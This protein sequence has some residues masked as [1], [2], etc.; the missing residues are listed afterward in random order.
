[1][2][3]SQ[4]NIVRN[5]NPNQTSS[6]Y[7]IARRELNILAFASQADFDHFGPCSSPLIQARTDT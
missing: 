6:R 5:L 2:I 3:V 7:A 1:M 4:R